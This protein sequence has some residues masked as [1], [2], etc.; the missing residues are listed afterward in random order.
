M[1]LGRYS[2][3]AGLSSEKRRENRAGHGT[4][5]QVMPGRN[6]GGAPAG[7]PP[8]QE[9]AY[10]ALRGLPVL[11]GIPNQELWAAVSSGLFFRSTTCC[12]TAGIVFRI[13]RRSRRRD[14]LV[15]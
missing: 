2:V 13:I 3:D 14:A 1:L 8:Q 5:Q 6:A 12:H 11:E 7:A 15:T 4:M 9:Q 10:R